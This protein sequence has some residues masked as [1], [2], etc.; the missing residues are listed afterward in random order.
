MHLCFDLAEWYFQYQQTDHDIYILIHGLFHIALD[1]VWYRSW[2]TI[3]VEDW[4]QGQYQKGHVLI[5]L[6]H[7]LPGQITCYCP[8][9][10]GRQHAANYAFIT[11]Q[12]R[13]YFNEICDKLNYRSVYV[14][15]LFTSYPSETIPSTILH[16]NKDNFSTIKI[17]KDL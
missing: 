15:V 3:S 12:I 4:C 16:V 6:S 1:I 10:E 2:W 9:Q 11:V 17:W 5:Y 8:S 14:Y 13:R 7:I